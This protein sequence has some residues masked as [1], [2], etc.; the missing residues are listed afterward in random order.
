MRGYNLDTETIT[1][2]HKLRDLGH[3]YKEIA[4]RLGIGKSTVNHRLNPMKPEV[5]AKAYARQKTWKRH[6]RLTTTI[7]GVHR[8]FKVLKRSRP[9]YCEL[10]KEITSKLYWHHWDDNYL[11]IGL[12]LCWSC[13]HFAEG[14]DKGLSLDLYLGLKKELTSEKLLVPLEVEITIAPYWS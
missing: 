4:I 10:C 7:N 12:W 6:N 1:Q 2:I 11:G 8:A 13:H 5:K 9:K 3:S 14:V